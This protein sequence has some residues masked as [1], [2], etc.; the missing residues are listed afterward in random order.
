[1]READFE[2]A[3]CAGAALL[4]GRRSEDNVIDLIAL[5]NN[6]QVQPSSPRRMPPLQDQAGPSGP[7]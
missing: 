3:V 6:I 5:I 4:G 1:M 2:R 7:N